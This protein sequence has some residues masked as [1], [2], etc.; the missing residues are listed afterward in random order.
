M[1]LEDA[2]KNSCFHVEAD[3]LIS[4][5]FLRRRSHVVKLL[6]QYGA[7]SDIR[8]AH[9]WVR[10][11]GDEADPTESILDWLGSGWRD[12]MLVDAALRMCGDR[13]SAERCMAALGLTNGT[14]YR[15]GVE[16]ALSLAM[17]KR[18]RRSSLSMAR[19]FLA[20][21][22]LR[23]GRSPRRANRSTSMRTPARRLLGGR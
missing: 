11:F 4:D 20:G 1:R 15:P 22:R 19:A 6:A 21:G 12:P 23:R 9:L 8:S 16:F 3:E 7:R 14:A 13:A 17:A 18:S 5:D 2:L 10:T